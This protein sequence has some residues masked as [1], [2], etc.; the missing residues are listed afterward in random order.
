MKLKELVLLLDKHAY[1]GN[2]EANVT[3]EVVEYDVD[4]NKGYANTYDLVKVVFS[5]D[6]V[7]LSTDFPAE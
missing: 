4:G 2:M 5:D 7:V 6:E 1:R 3:I